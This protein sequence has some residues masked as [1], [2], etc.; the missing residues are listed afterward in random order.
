M[1]RNFSHIVMFLLLLKF[2][3]FERDLSHSL[4]FIKVKSMLSLCLINLLNMFGFFLTFTTFNAFRIIRIRRSRG[5]KS[6]F[7]F[8]TECPILTCGCFKWIMF[9]LFLFLLF[10]F[11]CQNYWI[12]IINISWQDYVSRWI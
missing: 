2:N 6:I 9:L 3:H 8:R 12:F 5:L 7:K 10:P 11:C 4:C 1:V